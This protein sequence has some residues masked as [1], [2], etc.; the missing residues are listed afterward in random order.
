MKLPRR[1]KSLSF[2]IW[3]GVSLLVVI[4]AVSLHR[5]QDGEPVYNGVKVGSWLATIARGRIVEDEG[6]AFDALKGAGPEVVPYLM[7]II[8]RKHSRFDAMYNAVLKQLPICL[9]DKLPPYRD[10]AYMQL[11]AQSLL[12]KSSQPAMQ[13]AIPELLHL[14][15]SPDIELREIAAGVL[16]TFGTNSKPAL[17]HLLKYMTNSDWILRSEARQVLLAIGPEAKD[18][19]PALVQ[20][21]Q[22]STTETEVRKEALSALNKIDPDAWEKVRP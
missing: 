3:F 18:A 19:V 14:L 7:H 10:P 15:R 20:I 4:F 6:E 21:S 8:T 1:Q 9:Q 12:Q 5:W 2:S 11:K 13:A 16:S 17:P 22:N